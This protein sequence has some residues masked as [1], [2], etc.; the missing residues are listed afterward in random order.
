MEPRPALS[1]KATGIHATFSDAG[2]ERFASIKRVAR[3]R[4]GDDADA[5]YGCG[6]PNPSASAKRK[7]EREFITA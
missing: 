4:E 5:I 3:Q 1:K 2:C 6:N 7:E